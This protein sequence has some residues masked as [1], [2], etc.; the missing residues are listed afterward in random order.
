MELYLQ[1]LLV[2]GDQK[3]ESVDVKIYEWHNYNLSNICQ[4]KE[5]YYA[6]VQD[7]RTYL[8]QEG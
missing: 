1:E 8:Q 2:P 6:G 7:S 5:R 4:A 3:N